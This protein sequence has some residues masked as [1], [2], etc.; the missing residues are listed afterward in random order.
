MT[1]RIDVDFINRVLAQGFVTEESSYL[2]DAVQQRLQHLADAVKELE[3]IESK[4]I[5]LAT[6]EIQTPTLWADDAAQVQAAPCVEE[7]KPVYSFEAVLRDAVMIAVQYKNGTLVEGSSPDAALTDVKNLKLPDIPAN[8]EKHE[9]QIT[10]VLIYV[11]NTKNNRVRRIA[12][13]ASLAPIFEPSPV[14]T[15]IPLP[16]VDGRLKTWAESFND[17]WAESFKDELEEAIRGAE[18]YVQE[19]GNI[20]DGH[21]AA[22]DKFKRVNIFE[23]P[24]TISA[25]V[26]RLMAVSR[27]LSNSKN[28]IQTRLR[29]LAALRP[30]F[31]SAE[32]DTRQRDLKANELYAQMTKTKSYEGLAVL[33][34]ENLHFLD[35]GSQIYEP[36]FECLMGHIDD[37]DPS[38]SAL[39][40]AALKDI[41]RKAAF[42]AV[43]E[44]FSFYYERQHLILELDHFVYTIFDGKFD[45]ET[46][47]DLFNLKFQAEPGIEQIDLPRSLLSDY[48]IASLEYLMNSKAGLANRKQRFLRD[49]ATGVYGQ[50]VMKTF[51]KCLFSVYR[52]ALHNVGLTDREEFRQKLKQVAA[53]ANFI[54]LDGITAEAAEALSDGLPKIF[55]DIAWSDLPKVPKNYRA[56]NEFAVI[57]L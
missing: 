14:R 22:L 9:E 38:S 21:K 52:N 30:A 11:R 12:R 43:H 27:F 48:A 32:E 55:E 6:P 34:K 17:A 37:F 2:L 42:A 46:F 44:C 41:F 10:Q 1:A 45:K 56:S 50:E 28:S 4:L 5:Q 25:C 57:I 24:D 40:K 13:I 8:L 26:P 3:L 29:K 20:T 49:A 35:G 51:G 36:Y 33:V 18:S 16:A 31:D 23:T 15:P 53:S 7:T 39:T 54:V 47:L 19:P